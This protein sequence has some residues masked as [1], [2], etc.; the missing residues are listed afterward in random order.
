MNQEF[1]EY[2][3]PSVK[4]NLHKWYFAYD[5]L[6][7]EIMSVI[8]THS[9]Q[10]SGSTLGQFMRQQG[11]TE[12]GIYSVQDYLV[13][14]L[15]GESDEQYLER[16]AIAAYVP[17]FARGVITLAGILWAIEGDAQRTYEVDGKKTLGDPRDKKSIMSRLWRNADG[18]GNNW[19]VC[20]QRLT[21]NMIALKKMYGVVQGPKKVDGVAV[22]DGSINWVLPQNVLDYQED[23]SGNLIFAKILDKMTQR[24]EGFE[25][26]PEEMEV[27]FV[28]T[29]EGVQRFIEDGEGKDKKII[30][31]DPEPIP[32]GA[33]GFTFKASDKR[34]SVIPVFPVNLPIDS[35]VGYLMARADNTIFNLENALNFQLWVSG[36]PKLLLDAYSPETGYDEK[37]FEELSK[38]IVKGY[39]AL[40]GAGHRYIA[41]PVDGIEVKGARID[42]MV[43][44]YYFTFF[45]SY[46][47]AGKQATATEIRTDYRQGIEAFLTLV[48]DALD[49]A[50]N[51]ALFLL[52]QVNFFDKPDLWGTSEI[53]RS[54]DFSPVPISDLVDRALGYFGK[55]GEFVST[56]HIRK[57]LA[58]K[59]ARAAMID[60]DEDDLEVIGESANDIN[61][62]NSQED[63]ILTTLRR[64]RDPIPADV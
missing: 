44:D 19:P 20:M 23:E 11:T 27:A 63:D 55:D 5:L 1:F 40:P 57:Q 28:Y 39:N 64:N 14:H 7:G 36:F 22:N 3:H 50:E 45:Q 24:F 47:D 61:D 53:T 26:V 6:T 10:T 15:Q 8:D 52:E 48:S 31:L 12:T 29:L 30:P 9:I 21:S 42:Q 43:R 17:R 25:R 16:R 60:L 51:K 18:K 46:A 38:L 4:K 58:E 62:A 34:S 56:P 59:A 37:T 13:R 41:P 33:D 2:K 54:R 35:D 32:Y 49:E